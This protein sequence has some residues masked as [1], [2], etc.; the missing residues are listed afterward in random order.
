MITEASAGGSAEA[1]GTD[2]SPARPPHQ[3]IE[4][5]DGLRGLAAS[6]VL[7]GH[8]ADRI[9]VNV[10]APAIDRALDYVGFGRIGVVAFFCISGFVIPFSFREP[11]AVRNFA[12]SRFFRLYPAYW[13]S[14]AVFLPLG[15][16]LGRSVPATQIAAN[17]TMAQAAMG[18]ADVIH[19]YWT[20]FYELVFYLLCAIAFALGWLK[21]ARAVLLIVSLLALAAAA[22]A[23]LHYIGFRYR[24][25][26]GLPAYLSIMFFGTACRFAFLKREAFA[27]RWLAPLLVIL[28]MMVS[29]VA[30]LGYANQALP[31]RPLAD[32][33][34]V[35]LGI[36]LFLVAF[37]CKALLAR[38]VMV[39]LGRISYSLYL[40][41]VA[42]VLAGVAL[43]AQLPSGTAKLAV[44][45]ATIPFSLLVADLCARFVEKPAI[46]LGKA[47]IRRGRRAPIYE[48]I[49]PAP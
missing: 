8:V 33:L 34:G 15:A 48:G 28:A 43:A 1:T 47:I 42:C 20:L 7:I 13:L 17:L 19:V 35:Y 11:D 40:M 3:R 4:F 30:F 38:P 6:L 26:L 32:F 44:L 12:I 25:P 39:W 10:G 14:L 24:P 23:V 18:Q 45:L 46:A 16:A 29:A 21:S 41:Q 37:R 9:C 22:S 36:G 31:D 2:A 27:Q 5:L 49:D